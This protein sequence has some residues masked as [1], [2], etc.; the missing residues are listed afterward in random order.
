MP[1]FRLNVGLA[2]NLCCLSDENPFATYGESRWYLYHRLNEEN[3]R[4]R[5]TLAKSTSV[6]TIW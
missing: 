5:W 2:T 3:G 6:M 4:R 1:E